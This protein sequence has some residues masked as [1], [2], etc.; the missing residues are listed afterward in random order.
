MAERRQK[1]G[2]GRR[3]FLRG[4]AAA[5]LGAA[6]A[7]VWFGQAPAFAQGTTVT[8]STWGG[9]TE[10][11]IKDH[12]QKEY[13]K[14]TGAKLAYDIGGQG[15]RYNKLLAQRSSPTSDV[16][17][18]TDEAVISGMRANALQPA[19]KK[20]LPLIADMQDWSLTMK[21][22]DTAETVYGAPYTVLA[23][24][25]AYN[26]EF[27]KEKFTSW[28]DIWRPEFKGKL[29]FVAPGHSAMPAV[30]IMTAEMMGGGINNVEPAFKKL[31]ELKPAKTAFFWTEYASL[32]KS[33]DVT[34]CVDLD[35]YLEGM[36]E[37]KYPIE[38]VFPK[39]KGLGVMDYVSV[40]KGTKNPDLAE[41]FCNMIM[42][43]PVQEAFA[44]KTFSGPV[45][46][47]IKLTGVAAERCIYGP[48]LD[49]VR[50]FPAKFLADN[51]VAWT[52]KLNTEVV[53]NW[54]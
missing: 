10:D 39:E 36:K 26:P 37:Q 18:S 40:V 7:P 2:F 20:N 35:Y 6:G 33:N 41:H 25:P 53:P 42:S 29:A 4:A 15:A 52:E 44:T 38:Y 5:G 27:V 47:N 43:I 11:S 8:I 1:K 23:L 3:Q 31:S 16:F 9:L 24:V 34:V 21:E 13:E 19:K 12:M 32:Y 50:F 51:R 46:K 22:F 49:Q 17:F 28:A 14:Q 54:R 48:K 30:I 45:N